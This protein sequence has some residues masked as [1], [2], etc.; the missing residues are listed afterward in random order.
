MQRHSEA[1]VV[2][3]ATFAETQQLLGAAFIRVF[4]YFQEDGATSIDAIEA[5]MR[6]RDAAALV[7]P[8]HKLKSEAWQFG[9]DRL[10]R[11]AEELEMHGRMCVETHE[12][13]DDFVDRV[14][15]LRPLFN[16]MVQM[17]DRE[18]NPLVQRSQGFG[19]RAM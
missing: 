15:A 3:W 4:G 1:P 19:R 11:F 12:S 8:A 14:V 18:I 16:E 17:I 10:G 13:P 2:D 5:A 9:G 7:A 6:A